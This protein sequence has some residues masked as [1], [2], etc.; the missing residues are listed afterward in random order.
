GCCTGRVA[1]RALADR[2][3]STCTRGEQPMTSRA[4]LDLTALAA[5][6]AEGEDELRLISRVLAV[7]PYAAEEV[8]PPPSLRDDLLMRLRQEGDGRGTRFM[9][10]PL[11][12]A[13]GNEIEW[14]AIAPGI[15]SR[16]LY[17]DAATG[18]QTILVRMEPNTPFP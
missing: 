17:A 2:Q 11:Y 13:R 6:V 16:A 14:T 7:L 18:A 10:G 5:D 15:F 4:P 12:F 1:E 8:A 9:D 3:P